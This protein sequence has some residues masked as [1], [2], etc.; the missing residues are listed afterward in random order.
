MYGNKKKY[1]TISIALLFLLIVFFFV[2]RS[3]NDEDGLIFE[4]DDNLVELLDESVEA[5]DQTETIEQLI[6]DIKGEIENP[7]VY[8]LDPGARIR[9]L[10][11]QAGGFT[12]DADE[13]QI[14][15]AQRVQDEMI[16]IVPKIGEEIPQQLQTG[17]GDISQ[18]D[19][20]K[21]NQATQEDMMKLKGIGPSKAQAIID[22][23]EENGPF[24]HV[25]DLLQVTGIGEKTLENIR[26]EIIIP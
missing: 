20:I 25:E 7:G 26:D 9:D 18:N 22:Y 2:L 19:G 14:N 5:T 10:V 3:D 11:Q 23:R 16:V 13:R 6:V 15:L 17:S 12:T 4:V 1:I 21:V 24:Q 8:T